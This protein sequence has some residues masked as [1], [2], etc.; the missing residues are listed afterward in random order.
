MTA[1]YARV[2]GSGKLASMISTPV[3]AAQFCD[4]LPARDRT[5]SATN[6][7]GRAELLK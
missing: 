5:A 7:D 6:F 1:S 2:G 4:V 3:D